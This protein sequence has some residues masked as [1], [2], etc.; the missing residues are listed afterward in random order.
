MNTLKAQKL[1]QDAIQTLKVNLQAQQQN[2]YDEQK[3]QSQSYEKVSFEHQTPS[4][5]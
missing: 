2:L 5:F 1:Q 3:K 4:I